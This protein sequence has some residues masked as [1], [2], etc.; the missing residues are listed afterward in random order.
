MS[1]PTF[2]FN[3]NTMERGKSFTSTPNNFGGVINADGNTIRD[4]DH[5]HYQ[6]DE[7]SLEAVILKHLKQDTSPEVIKQTVKEIEKLEDKNQ[8]TIF[9]KLSEIGIKTYLE[10]GILLTNL[11]FAIYQ[12]FQ[13]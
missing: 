3:N 6:R 10:G 9:E 2:N 4:V 11:A 7:K 1:K 13:P 8:D 5:F 12:W